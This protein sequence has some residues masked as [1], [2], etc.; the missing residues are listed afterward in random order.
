MTPLIDL[1][2]HYL[3]AV[4]DG[5]KSREDGLALLRELRTLGFSLVVAT[6]HIRSGMFEN[7]PAQLRSA[8]ADF[9]AH[10]AVEKDLP[11][12]ALAAEHHVDDLAMPLLLN[13]EGLSYP[14]GQ[15]VLVEFPDERLPIRATEMF[16]DLR[17]KG[18][19]PV[20]AHPE[21]YATFAK[22]SEPLLPFVEG[23][24]K[25]LLDIMSLVGH[26]GRRTRRAAERLL[27]EN[28]Y[29]AACTD[30][31]RVAQV[32]TVHEGMKRLSKLQGQQA[33]QQLFY[34]GPADII[35]ASGMSQY[36][37]PMEQQP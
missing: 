5:V 19:T 2:C 36:R 7:Q 27:K 12:R 24:T 3:P 6:P 30:T 23:G 20:L 17:M 35:G 29:A 13:G 26:Y 28:L 14:G 18:L 34:D 31:H 4:D 10:C 37:K 22:S 11:E 32:A 16:F 25:L 8:F 21:R 33:I 1:H 9:D 15:S